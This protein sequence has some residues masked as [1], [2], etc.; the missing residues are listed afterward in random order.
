M[1]AVRDVIIL[2]SDSHTNTIMTPCE[3]NGDVC[4]GNT[5]LKRASVACTSGIK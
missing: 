5:G 4:A 1:N 2:Q 3:Q